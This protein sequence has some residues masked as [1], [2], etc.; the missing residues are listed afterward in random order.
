[1]F[2]PPACPSVSRAPEQRGE[3]VAR[4]VAESRDRLVHNIDSVDGTWQLPG[5]AREFRLGPGMALQQDRS[6]VLEQPPAVVAPERRRRR[7]VVD[8]EATAIRGQREL[9][10]LR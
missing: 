10:R 9:V 1:M 4:P 8:V 2:D 3:V 7:N 5:A 6:R